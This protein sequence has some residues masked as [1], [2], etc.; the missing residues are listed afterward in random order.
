MQR[1]WT[2]QVKEYCSAAP[3]TPWYGDTG[4]PTAPPCPWARREARSHKPC[5][6]VNG[7][8]CLECNWRDSES[9]PRLWEWGLRWDT[10][11]YHRQSAQ[12]RWQHSSANNLAKAHGHHQMGSKGLFLPNARQAMHP[13][14]DQALAFYKTWLTN[15][16]GSTGRNLSRDN[17]GALF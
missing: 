13:S 3:H 1:T 6:S 17:E 15:I 16:L 8:W 10:D 5:H 9:L 7:Q 14:Q 4:W 12:K 11:M 2:L